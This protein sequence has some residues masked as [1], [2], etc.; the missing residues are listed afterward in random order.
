MITSLK[1]GFSFVG[2]VL[3]YFFLGTFIFNGLNLV[4]GAILFT[5]PLYIVDALGV[6]K[7]LGYGELLLYILCI[8]V[9]AFIYGAVIGYII[10]RFNTSIKNY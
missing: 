7:S 5:F 10:S 4:P 3:V 9:M 2:I 8:P 1:F 6:G